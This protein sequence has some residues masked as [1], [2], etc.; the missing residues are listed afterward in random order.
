MF[1]ELQYLSRY[2][3]VIGCKSGMKALIWHSYRTWKAICIAFVLQ[4][5]FLISVQDTEPTLLD[6]LQLSLSYALQI[7]LG[8][9]LST[10]N[11]SM[12]LNLFYFQTS[13]LT[14]NFEFCLLLN[15]A[16]TSKLLFSFIPTLLNLSTGLVPWNLIWPGQDIHYY[17]L[18]SFIL[19]SCIYFSSRIVIHPG[20]AHL[21]YS[22]V[23]I[24]VY[25]NIAT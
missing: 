13:P 21:L 7:P 22:S 4:N 12:Y 10:T 9:K 20:L 8:S 6:L 16:S 14:L 25:Q 23:F 3:L 5:Q 1:Y 17:Q 11:S 15:F 18:L 24:L 2:Y 19:D